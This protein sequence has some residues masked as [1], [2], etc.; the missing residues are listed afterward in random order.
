LVGE[1]LGSN[2][3]TVIVFIDKRS[4]SVA[5]T[6]AETIITYETIVVSGSRSSYTGKSTVII[7]QGRETRRWNQITKEYSAGGS[8]A[9]NRLWSGEADHIFR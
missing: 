7:N 4:V 3:D 9:E 5:E 6:S 2:E 8:G 1:W